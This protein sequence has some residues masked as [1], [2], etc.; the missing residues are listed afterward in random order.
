MELTHATKVILDPIKMENISSR[1]KAR[2]FDYY[3]Y[4]EL[5]YQTGALG[6]KILSL[7]VRD[8]ESFISTYQETMSR[9]LISEIKTHISPKKKNDW[10]LESVRTP[11]EP[12]GKRA[13]ENVLNTVGQEE[14]Y[15]DFGVKNITRTFYY[16]QFR[17]M[18]YNYEKLLLL[19]KQRHKH[20]GSLE[21]FLD[22]CELTQEDFKN[23][24]LKNLNGSN[25]LLL[26][27]CDYIINFFETAKSEITNGTSLS[28]LD[29]NNYVAMLTQT[30]AIISR[31]MDK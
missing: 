16:N 11:G 4:F 25:K 18:E 30:K 9:A 5:A 24:I 23:D 17:C 8:M 27:D 31:Y 26:Q 19:F 21:N 7:K 15:S 22:Y 10:L 3:L 14:G 1:L 20:I 12:L 13:I 28:G 29:V 6:S 2:H